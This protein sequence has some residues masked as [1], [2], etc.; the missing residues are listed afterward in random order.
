MSLPASRSA[1]YHP[2][3]EVRAWLIAICVLVTVMVSIGGITRLTGS[4]LSITDWA[5]IM[6]AIPPLSEADWQVAFE[7]YRQIP[8]YRLQNSHLSLG[9]FKFLF[10]WEWFHRLVGRLIGLVSFLPGIWFF[11]RGRISKR[12][13]LRVLVG[14]FLGGLQGALGW[15]MVK[16]GLVERTSVSHYRL[17]AHLVLALVILAYFV[18]L[19]RSVFIDEKSTREETP[20][21]AFVRP[22]YP[23]LA[24]LFFLQIVY[25]AFVAG[26]KAGFA[27]NTFPLMAGALVPSNLFE[28]TP[29]WTNLFENPA[30]IQWIHRI[31]GWA[32]FFS[33]NGLW[34]ALARR[35]V[36]RGEIHRQVAAIAQM[37]IVQFAL[38]VATLVWVVPLTLAVLHQFGAAL[39]VILLTRLGHQLHARR[40]A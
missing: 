4:G 6:G 23:F 18:W 21:S 10:F 17:A 28:L 5:P 9:D 2:D 39:L 15:F 26:M 24:A 8:Q 22:F 30:T 32:A 1:L 27:F 13:A 33:T 36:P 11:F 38:G 7:K 40:S 14:I 35:R 20:G 19:T 29:G 3:P 34:F 12:L 31:L 16:S 37:T 25:G